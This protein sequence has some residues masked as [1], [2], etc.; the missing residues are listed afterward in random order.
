M[1]Q[2]WCELLP[3]YQNTL[4]MGGMA[5]AQNIDIRKTVGCFYLFWFQDHPNP[6]QT[7]IVPLRQ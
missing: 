1:P 7:V 6:Y 3:S 2:H 4:G 5:D